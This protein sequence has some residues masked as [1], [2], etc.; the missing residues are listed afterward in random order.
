MF[1]TREKCLT[2]SSG[3]GT[4][5]DDPNVIQPICVQLGANLLQSPYH[6]LAALHKHAAASDRCAFTA[7]KHWRL[8]SFVLA[9]FYHEA[10]LRCFL[11]LDINKPLSSD[12]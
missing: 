12:S 2:S 9:K 10:L 5:F 11:G 8:S 4:W 3:L 6:G 7:R 1:K